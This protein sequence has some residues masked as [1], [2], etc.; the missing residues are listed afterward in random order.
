MKKI[1]YLALAVAFLCVTGCTNSFTTG[2]QTVSNESASRA[3]T[4]NQMG[5][6]GGYYYSFWTDGGGTTSMTLGSGGN[7]STYWSNCG[8]FVAGKGW[9]T[10]G[11]NSV[12]YSGRFNPSGNG[13]LS[14]YGWT[15]SP[16][17]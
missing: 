16:L 4:S 3:L 17:V 2:D 10:G 7:Y 8:N 9:Q 13:Y 5:T 11:R 6:N 1:V 15:T 14:L 12:A